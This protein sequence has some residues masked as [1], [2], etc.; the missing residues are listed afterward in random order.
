MA[1]E[2]EHIKLLSSAAQD[3][4]F[5]YLSG[6]SLDISFQTK[7]LMI[8]SE[9]LVLKNVVP[10]EFIKQLWASKQFTLQAKMTRFSSDHVESDGL[11]IVFHIQSLDIIEETRT[12]PRFLFEPEERV[13]CELLNPYDR[14]TWL[15]KSVL[16]MSASGLSISCGVASELFAQGTRF[17]TIRVVID[18]EPYTVTSGTVVHVRKLLEVNGKMRAQVGFKLDP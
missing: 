7:V 12:A 8:E 10:P 1:L 11:N 13:I 3:G 18:G 15:A 17:D 2:L 16:D 6:S 5:V 14:E 4:S 9:K